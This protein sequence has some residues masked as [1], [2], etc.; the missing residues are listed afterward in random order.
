MTPLSLFPC[1]QSFGQSTG[2]IIFGLMCNSKEFDFFIDRLHWWPCLMTLLSFKFSDNAIGAGECVHAC[3]RGTNMAQKM[4]TGVNDLI[5]PILTSPMNTS[6]PAFFATQNWWCQE[7]HVH[8]RH[9]LHGHAE[10]AVELPFRKPHWPCWSVYLT[11]WATLP[12]PL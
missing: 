5:L 3:L 9:I 10:K 2:P 11:A 12:Q 7:V 1:Y 4:A 8:C 6:S